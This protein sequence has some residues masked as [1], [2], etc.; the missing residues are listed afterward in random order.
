MN[1]GG[2]RG[3]SGSGFENVLKQ[4]SVQRVEPADHFSLRDSP[5]MEEQLPDS[6]VNRFDYGIM[7]AITGYTDPMSQATR[8]EHDLIDRPMKRVY[9]D[10]TVETFTYEG[11]RINA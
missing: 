9:P 4:P 7:G 1:K 10:G 3:G 6:S 5:A 11:Q 2:Q 8:V